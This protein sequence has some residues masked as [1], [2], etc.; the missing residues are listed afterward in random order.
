[1]TAPTDPTPVPPLV[2]SRQHDW[3]DDPKQAARH[4]DACWEDRFDTDRDEE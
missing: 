3:D 1:M 2:E 4:D